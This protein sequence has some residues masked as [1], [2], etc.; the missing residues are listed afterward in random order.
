MSR[1]YLTREG[2]EKLVKDLDHLKGP[3]R[4]QIAKD[5]EKARALGDL[6]ENAE[7]DSA[8][9]A[10]AHL[11]RQIADLSEKLANAQ[12]IM[13]GQVTGDKVT[14]ATTVKLKDLDSEEEIQYTLVSA[15]EADPLKDK[16]SV[17]SPIGK[18]LIG[19]RVKDKVEIQVP[20]GT[21]KYQILAIDV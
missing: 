6:K 1:I 12:I 20:A 8:K 9:D 16:I 10:Q 11:E 5:L 21:L 4:R 14:I 15:E 18:A 2:H 13:K 3:R 19:K 17:T 7:Y